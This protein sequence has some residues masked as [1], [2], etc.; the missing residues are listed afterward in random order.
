MSKNLVIYEKNSLNK[1]IFYQR[2]KKIFIENNYNNISK[3]N[4]KYTK[5]NQFFNAIEI[6]NS[7]LRTSKYIDKIFKKIINCKIGKFKDEDLNQAENTFKQKIALYACDIQR[8]FYFAKLVKKKFK[9]KGKIYLEANIFNYKVYK[10][11]KDLSLLDKNID[12]TYEVKTISFI[13]YYLKNIYFFFKT[14]FI[15]EVKLLKTSFFK[16][17][18][19]IKKKKLISI[20]SKNIKFNRNDLDLS[21]LEKGIMKKKIIY[22]TESKNKTNQNFNSTRKII[23]IEEDILQKFNLF[24]F[25]KNF[26][27]SFFCKKIKFLKFAFKYPIFFNVMFKSLNDIINWKIFYILF[28]TKFH[29][30]AMSDEKVFIKHV[31]NKNNVKTIFLYFSTTEELIPIPNNKGFTRVNYAYLNYDY[32]VADK[33][34]IDLFRLQKTKVK[35]F[36]EIGNIG[37]DIILKNCKNEKKKLNRMK[38]KIQSKYKVISFFDHSIGRDGIWDQFDYK[39]VLKN[40]LIL[41]ESHNFTIIY[42][43]KKTL[44]EL[45][46]N[47]SPENKITFNKILRY[48]NFK[49]FEGA[50]KTLSSYQIM[51]L[52]DL[53]ITAPVSSVISEAMCSLKKIL[54][55]D[56]NGK[57]KSKRYF[58][59]KMNEFYCKDENSFIIKLHK[60]INMNKKD[61]SIKIYS[62]FIKKK[63]KLNNCGSNLQN[64]ENILKNE[65]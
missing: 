37:S 31:H 17:S 25:I 27:L 63:L 2:F 49:Y 41:L 6:K 59:R 15:T 29:L 19:L 39:K 18:K 40:I 43:S 13:F 16:K 60:I 33:I 7:D 64:F 36:I 5:I 38:L 53:I 8:N 9:L 56:P 50:N 54:V 11:M 35:N 22:V 23:N 1:I 55:Y 61:Y 51:S 4:I 45:Y 10:T 62:N 42:K 48:K 34:S 20:Y 30:N 26:Y 58:I 46:E 14:L 3:E 44:I 28:E 24:Y 47:F 52:S 65:L 12:Y 57:Y 32:F 21:F